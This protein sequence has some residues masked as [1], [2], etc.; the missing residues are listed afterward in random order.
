MISNSRVDSDSSN[1]STPHP[2]NVAPANVNP[3]VT[4]SI[5][6]PAIDTNTY[7]HH[8]QLPV[9]TTAHSHSMA[10]SMYAPST[11]FATNIQPNMVPSHVYPYKNASSDYSRAAELPNKTWDQRYGYIVHY[12]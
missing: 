3:N 6:A 7:G 11:S 2:L 1:R 8:N 12:I 10:G 5:N 9:A 4:P